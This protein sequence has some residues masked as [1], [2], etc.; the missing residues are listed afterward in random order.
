VLTAS[1]DGT[2]RVWDAQTGQPLTLPLEHRGGVASAEFSPDGR[3]VLTASGEARLW[4]VSPDNR[5]L[6]ELFLLSQV[7]SSH[8][9]DETGVL[10]PLDADEYRRAWER[11]RAN[12]PGS[13]EAAGE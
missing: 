6:E 11:L 5:P 2:A 4:D 10:A 9:L 12:Y 3:R 13:L 7:L 8:R 1:A